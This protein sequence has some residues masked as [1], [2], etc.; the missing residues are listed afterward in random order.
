[1][2]KYQNGSQKRSGSVDGFLS[3][4]PRRPL[5]APEKKSDSQHPLINVYSN[6]K[7]DDFNK[8][9]GFRG[10]TVPQLMSNAPNSGRNVR[11][12]LEDNKTNGS[13]RSNMHGKKRAKRPK[14]RVKKIILWVF[15]PIIIL[16]LGSG[17]YLFGKAWWTAHKVFNGK[18]TTALAFQ[19]DID[20]YLLKG[21]GDGR[22]N[23]LLLGKGGEGHA[24]AELTDS[25]LI[26]SLD[27]INNTATFLSVPRD[28]WVAPKGLWAMKINKVYT[29]AKQKALTSNP[30][31]TA[32]AEAAGLNAT[33]QTV[34]DYLGV[35][36]HYYSIID[37]SAFEEVVNTLGGI[38]V[39]L[40]EAY[41]DGT[42]LVGNKYLNLPAGTQHLD[43]GIALA[44]ARSRYGAAR[45]DFDRGEHQQIVLVGIKDK[46]L[47]LGTFANPLK[48]SSLLNT[49]GNRIQTNLSIDDFLRVY[50]FS[51]KL[52]SSKITHSDLAEQPNAVVTTSNINGE[53]VVIPKAGAADYSAVK[54]FVRNALKDG[55]IVKENP[56][57]TVLNGTNQSGLAQQQA[58][59]L[60]GWGYNVVKV[61]DAPLK[62]ATNNQVLDNTKGTKKYT[63]RYLEQRFGA[64]AVTSIEGMDLSLYT[65]DFIIV[66][67]AKS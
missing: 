37:F 4:S 6:N 33:C 64:T 2:Y 59:E 28:L 13:F 22:V 45:G 65:S 63:L 5:S 19:K 53:S 34:E 27:P 62:N 66:V 57:I 9:D 43:G 1:M 11:A 7:I 15:V 39:T 60:K 42:M 10:R 49:F 17:G 36:M 48:I 35:H 55:Y 54:S 20:P 21:E 29:Y 30:K 31:D 56:S 67:G 40:P 46:V 3:S 58:D 44:Y 41:Y 51:K 25:M 32:A 23:V 47:S 14:G 61:A 18:G 8:P 52:E 12:G 50:E 38:D 16:V 24:G 26:A